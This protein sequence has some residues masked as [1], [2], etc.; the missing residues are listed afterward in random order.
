MG[1]TLYAYL[2]FTFHFAS[3]PIADTTNGQQAFSPSEVFKDGTM[4][5]DVEQGLP[6]MRVHTSKWWTIRYINMI[7]MLSLLILP[8]RRN[9]CREPFAEFLGVCVLIIF[10]TGVDCQVVL[11]TDPNVAPSQRGVRI[12]FT[13]YNWW[14]ADPS[15]QG[16]ISINFGWAIGTAIGLWVAGGI[17]GAHINPAASPNV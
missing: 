7:S 8:P 4:T 6:Q 9:H 10:G 15:S 2:L 5:P 3:M 16:Y 17:S 13:L 1:E 11:S 12:I 14:R